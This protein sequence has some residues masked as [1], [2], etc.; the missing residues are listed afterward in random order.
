M[1]DLQPPP[2]RRQNAFYF[3]VPGETADSRADAGAEPPCR[4]EPNHSSSSAT[5]E[6]S[7]FGST[8]ASPMA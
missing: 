5:S 7:R 8:T 3:S 1:C 6:A 4:A 2:L